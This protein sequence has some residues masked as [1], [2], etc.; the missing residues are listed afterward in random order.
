MDNLLFT[1]YI[2]T[3][4]LLIFVIFYSLYYTIPNRKLLKLEQKTL[5][6]D[7]R[8]WVPCLVYSLL[9]GYRYDYGYDWNQYM[10][11]F[12]YIQRGWLYREDTETGYLV[13]NRLLGLLGFN[14][15]SIF[16]L[17][18]F[19]YIFSVC[20]FLKDNR[21]LWILVVPIIYMLNKFNCLNISRQFFAMSIMLIGYRFFLEQKKLIFVVLSLLASSIHMSSLL[22]IIPLFF[23]DRIRLPIWISICIFIGCWIFQQYFMDILLKSSSFAQQYVLKDKL[24]DENFLLNDRFLRDEVSGKNAIYAFTKGATYL[25]SCYYFC[26]P[27]FLNNVN[28]VR[29]GAMLR[30]IL[31]V[32]L[33]ALFFQVAA[34]SHEIFSRVFYMSNLFTQI[35]WGIIIYLALKNFNKVPILLHLFLLF[36]IVHTIYVFYIDTIS[37]FILGISIEYK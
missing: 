8:F 32:G 24:Y 27:I 30:I 10:N 36:F 1:I 3:F 13:I 15:Y 20:F 23:S 6:L 35:G 26:K 2:F 19:V 18:G 31:F 34:G 28:N 25:C 7:W 21:R 16:I 12:N 33:Y 5:L 9:L 17:E 11:T 22:F 4:I 37:E 14:Y 29:N